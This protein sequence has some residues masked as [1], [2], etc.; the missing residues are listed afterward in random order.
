MW[1]NLQGRGSKLTHMVKEHSPAWHRGFSLTEPEMKGLDIHFDR[2]C[3]PTGTSLNNLGGAG[4]VD[5]CHLATWGQTRDR[6]PS[7]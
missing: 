5:R 7:R 3:D 4:L 2:S 1:I 6:F